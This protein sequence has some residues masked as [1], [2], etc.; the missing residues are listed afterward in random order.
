MT[1]S[2]TVDRESLAPHDGAASAVRARAHDGPIRVAFRSKHLG[3]YRERTLA[4]LRRACRA[5]RASALQTLGLSSAA[6]AS[7]SWATSAR[8]G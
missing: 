7:P 2:V 3:I 1:A 8:N 6:S 4:R 5:H